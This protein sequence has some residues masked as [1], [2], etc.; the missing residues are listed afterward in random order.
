M[1][2]LVKN[3]GLIVAILV[4][5]IARGEIVLETEAISV[6]IDGVGQITSLIDR[7]SQREYA[8]FGQASPLLQVY[9]DGALHS[10]LRAS[11]DES[12]KQ[13]TLGFSDATIFVDVTIKGTHLTFEIVDVQAQNAVERVQ[14]GPIATSIK[15]TAGEVV[16]VVRD[17]QFAIGLQGM[18]VRTLGGPADNPEG[19]DVS[20][21]RSAIL[22]DWGS[23][24][25][26]YSFDRSLPRNVDVWGGQFPNM[27][28]LPIANETVVG[29]K[30]AL[31]GV[32]SDSVL[33]RLGQIEI[34]EGL[35]HPKY[36]GVW[37]RQNPELGRSYLIA[38]F[39]EQT[40]DEMLAFAKRGN[41]LSL[42]HPGPFKSWG[43]YELSPRFFPN[44]ESGMKACTEKAKAAGL[45]IGVHTLTNFINTNDPFV[46]PIPDHRL[47]KTG[48]SV[49]VGDI[50]PSDTT[51]QVASP[52]YFN[53]TKS[54]WLRT[55]MIGKELI[56]YGRVSD[57]APWS[58]L[59]CS[60]GA[61]GTGAAEHA[62]GV[63]VAKLMDHPYKVFLANYELQQDVAKRLAGLF[64]RTGIGH[65]DFDGH[66]GCHSSGQGDY[67]IEMF[68]KVFYDN[69]DHFVHN[70]TS[71]SQPF[72]WHI[73]T[74][75]NWGEPWYGGFRSS[76]ADYRIS[77]QAMLERNYMPKMLGWFQLTS[78]TTLADIEWLMARSAGYNS[79]F[80]MS[81]S[82]SD[83]NGNPLTNTLLDT[84][85]D[86]ETLRMQDAF[87]ESQRE[88]MRDTDREFHLAKTDA[89]F[90]LMPSVNSSIYQHKHYVRQPGEPTHADWSYKQTGA[91]QPIHFEL[92]L[93]GTTGTIDNLMFE[94][95]NHLSLAVPLQV[96]AGQT[97]ICDGSTMLRLYDTKGQHVKQYKLAAALPSLESGQHDVRFSCDFEGDPK[98]IVKVRFKSFGNGEPIER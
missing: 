55:V 32:Q 52:E 56:R 85:R 78:N 84:I 23:T 49:L 98:P 35:P 34:A 57:Q 65:L 81:T 13:I 8:A 59:D 16:G 86:W 88:A 70:G 39:S 7:S 36:Q 24:L 30:V 47:A 75:C 53:N 29:S 71:N 92:E 41:F 46:T 50:G 62:D 9:R 73:N 89:G 18:N 38:E 17:D 33:E 61:F 94:F 6:K 25:Q 15:T 51:I 58:L 66:E 20:R 64:N 45:L 12:K 87:S 3:F 76:M 79:G 5:G 97:L 90:M 82:R 14:W 22:T 72:Y 48:S 28:V 96:E 19:R 27:P 54:N 4:T 42:Y 31:F 43:H 26:A 44:G 69:V 60:R 91:N 83:L 77:N 11:L 2:E 40:I 80:A 37:S 63:E 74:C 93:S 10:P 67:A 95:D 68:A 1:S 21:G